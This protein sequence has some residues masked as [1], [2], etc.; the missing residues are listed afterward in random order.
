MRLDC[1]SVRGFCGHHKHTTTHQGTQ[2]QRKK[3]HFWLVFYFSC[4]VRLPG[5]WGVGFGE[6][7]PVG[8]SDV[9]RVRLL[10]STRHSLGDFITKRIVIYQ[11]VFAKNIQIGR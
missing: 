2:F 5:G 4:V 3:D 9:G 1:D 10:R 6:A 11:K 7:I 8:H